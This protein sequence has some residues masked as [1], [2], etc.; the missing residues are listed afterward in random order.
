MC[1]PD[2]DGDRDREETPQVEGGLCPVANEERPLR[3]CGTAE[4]LSGYTVAVWTCQVCTA[5]IHV[6]DDPTAPF[7][8]HR[9]ADCRSE[10]LNLSGES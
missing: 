1:G 3:F 9:R 2:S 7:G 8:R 6:P 5:E 10:C 4:S